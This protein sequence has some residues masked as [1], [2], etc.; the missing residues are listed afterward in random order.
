MPFLHPYAIDHIVPERFVLDHPLGPH[1]KTNLICITVQ[2]HA[3]KRKAEDKLLKNG[4]MLTYLTKLTQL[5]WPMER[6]HLALKF[7]GIK[8]GPIGMCPYCDVK[9]ETKP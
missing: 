4:D 5:G 3:A 9:T 1:A 7:Y 6:V 8:H 2:E